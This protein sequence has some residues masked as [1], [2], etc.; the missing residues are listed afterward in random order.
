MSP[1]NLDL[2]AR[3]VAV[4]FRNCGAYL[5]LDPLLRNRYRLHHD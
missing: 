5:C 4:R 3:E 2:G 1:V